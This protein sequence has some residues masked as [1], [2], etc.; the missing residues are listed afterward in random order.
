MIKEL[1]K[2]F[3]IFICLITTFCT[4]SA[5]VVTDINQND[6]PFKTNTNIETNGNITNI[7]TNTTI[8]GGTVGVNT[9]GRF[10][11]GKGDIVN[12]HLVDAQNKL[13]NLI[14]DNSA[15]QINGI[16]NSYMAGKIGGNVLFANPNGFVI[17]ADGV[18]N[19]G[20]LT[21]MTPNQ[22][23]MDSF[24]N[25]AI[26]E[27]PATLNESQI[28][29]LISFSFNGDNYLVG[30]DTVDPI[31]LAP[32]LIE[33]SGKI[34]SANGIDL[35]S[36]GRVDI[37]TGAQ[38]NANVEFQYD[39]SDIMTGFAPKTG[40]SPSAPSTFAMNDGN[41]IIIVASNDGSSNDFLGAIVNLDGNIAANG[42]NVIVRTEIAD[43][44][45][46]ATSQINMNAIL[47]AKELTL[48][49]LNG[50]ITSSGADFTADSVTLFALNDIKLINEGDIN[51]DS[52]LSDNN[53]ITLI[54]NQGSIKTIDANYTIKA[55]AMTLSAKN[56]IEIGN[57]ESSS[58][59]ISKSGSVDIK[60]L[61]VIG[62]INVT[63][64]GL[65]KIETINSDSFD[66]TAVDVDITTLT[67]EN[68]TI[69]TT[70]LVKLGTIETNFLDLTAGSVEISDLTSENRSRF[71]VDNSLTIDKATVGFID[72]QAKSINVTTSLKTTKTDDVSYLRATSGDINIALLD[73]AGVIDLTSLGDVANISIISATV[74][75]H[76][77]FYSDK[78][79]SIGT[80][81]I[82]GELIINSNTADIT[83]L[84]SGNTT[85]TTKGAT[86]VGTGNVTGDFKV[87]NSSSFTNNTKLTVSGDTNIKSSGAVT[88]ADAESQ[89]LTID[90]LSSDITSLTSGNTTITTSGVTT[91]GTATVDSLTLKSGSA[92]ITDITSAGAGSI[93]TGALTLG[94]GSF[95]DITVDSTTAN[96][97]SLTSAGKGSITTG[98]LTLG[99]GSFGDVTIS[100]DTVDVTTSLT[101]TVGSADITANKGDL[102]ISSLTTKTDSKLTST[103]G[104]LT[105][106]TL[107]STGDAIL[108]SAGNLK[109]TTLNSKSNA[110]LTSAAN[111]EV[112]NL[113]SEQNSTLTA[114]NGTVTLDSVDVN[115][116][117]T[118][119]SKSFEVTTAM[120][121]DGKVGI[122]AD[123]ITITPD[124]EFTD[125][126]IDTDV[127]TFDKLTVTGK[128]DITASES[129]TVD[130]ASINNLKLSS[131]DINVITKM[132]VTGTGNISA[133]GKITADTIS[134]NSL[135]KL[136]AKNIEIDNLT[137]T[138][139]NDK[140]I[141]VNEE[142]KVG[143]ATFD[144]IKISAGSVNVTSLETTEG[145]AEITTTNALTVGT[146][147]TKTDATLTA[148]KGNINLTTSN[149]DGNANITTTVGNIDLGKTTIEGSL[150]ANAKKDLTINGDTSVTGKTTLSAG[151]NL[152]FANTQN[153]VFN[154]GL[155]IENTGAVDLESLTVKGDASIEAKKIDIET[156]VVNAGT[157][158]QFGD[159][160]IISDGETNIK[161][162]TIAHDLT[163]D[164][165]HLNISD[166]L[167]VGGTANLGSNSDIYIKDTDINILDT[168][169]AT[170]VTIDN[171]NVTTN[172]TIIASGDVVLT[173]TTIG[174]DLDLESKNLTLKDTTDVAGKTTL[175]A[176]EKLV[177]E[178]TDVTFKD[179]TILEG[180]GTVDINHL[181]ITE[182]ANINSNGKT[183]IH[184]AD[185]T[186]N[187]TTNT[188]QMEVYELNVSDGNTLLRSL[189][190][191]TIHNA[192][193]DDLTTRANN[194]T[195]DTMTVDGPINTHN[196]GNL[197]VTDM[198]TAHDEVNMR[199]D[200]SINIKDAVMEK[201]LNLNSKDATIQE[202]T[203]EGNLNGKV[204][205]LKVNTEKTEEL[206]IGYIQGKSKSYATS[207]KIT[208]PNTVINGLGEE[209]STKDINI[210]GKNITIDA[211]TQ[212]A[213]PDKQLNFKLAKNNNIRLFSDGTIDVFTTGA[214][215]NYRNIVT[216][217]LN[218]KTDS[219]GI[220]IYRA[221][222][223]TYGDI[224]LDGKHIII[225][226]TTWAPD[227]YVTLQLRSIVSPHFL[228][229]NGSP[230]IRTQSLNA[231]RH[232]INIYVNKTKDATSMN[233]WL[234]SSMEGQLKTSD[235]A[236]KFYDKTD[237]NLNTWATLDSYI[238]KNF[239]DNTAESI[240]RTVKGEIITTDNVDELINSN[241][242]AI[243]KRRRL[244]KRKQN[245]SMEISC[246]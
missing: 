44:V 137:I 194:M 216:D 183:T 77:G 21:L 242:N 53:K 66:L 67:S 118:S 9:F 115:G 61:D 71:V 86:V 225:D 161:T 157:D 107:D 10:N 103:S 186:G 207:T 109:V 57:I 202:I 15:S 72:V 170:N 63:T 213:S 124:V 145:S 130:T 35:I 168:Q 36:G 160:K 100:A 217:N 230:F 111:I 203:L 179:L 40:V 164:V 209:Y 49:A 205:K 64:T 134:I 222:V 92:E 144:N 120:A 96:I 136:S 142:F 12:L 211:T 5:A 6:V 166:K 3:V 17:G 171:L 38:L 126:T 69:D 47:S 214:I 25:A 226:N 19:V 94:T 119:V 84:T 235:V 90:S 238:A 215:G 99:I 236:E 97:T 128:A 60:A 192:Q 241:P 224:R 201:D 184:K 23:A 180:T 54:S 135:E 245:Q 79:V 50:S 33:V 81:N 26:G 59:N 197:Q 206:K 141:S 22:Q 7:T 80:G 68:T 149:V 88:L 200:A 95:G 121:V 1:K 228:F 218:I 41:G 154:N 227:L 32:S 122:T 243:K 2:S 176:T 70:G 162:A 232:G 14:Y 244:F 117:F 31:K 37:K 190:L 108:S 237:K 221:V 65:A 187:L 220:N 191:I 106:T 45:T 29:K 56:S 39:E 112:T 233:S 131:G 116:D 42:S 51:I 204:D 18:F 223:T 143:T 87:S 173:K 212:I 55:N 133:T 16:V 246:R 28:N 74:G 146:L 4:V 78:A 98:A 163:T 188:W 208:T 82:T 114:N 240:V 175:K 73:V 104:A 129:F 165:N 27:N 234:T 185:V 105:V 181:T 132:D 189:D 110:T 182:Q 138:N 34:N 177:F 158:G 8:K 193:L 178:P 24:V 229:V 152:V 231:L 13:V 91:I 11:V 150:S 123:N 239:A 46:G 195:I 113:K 85:I 125:L 52:I 93:T 210:Y 196:T 62:S 151:D 75:G 219:N 140:I 156:F 76:A 101:T 83:S 169:G 199:S 127:L 20:S 153:V 48:S 172:G 155:T 89:N 148:T 102:T 174:G 30:G 198:L 147:N 43:T 167:T 139:S 159:A 58:F